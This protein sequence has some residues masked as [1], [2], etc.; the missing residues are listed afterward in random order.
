MVDDV[1][2][3]LPDLE[4]PLGLHTE[5]GQVGLGSARR[6]KVEA[7]V[8]EATQERCHRL[9]V[10]LV[11]RYGQATAERDARFQDMEEI[12]LR[13]LVAYETVHQEAL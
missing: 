13:T 11:A 8:T 12:L 6:H 1:G 10:P 3:P 4:D 9:T 2:T 7:E 5:S